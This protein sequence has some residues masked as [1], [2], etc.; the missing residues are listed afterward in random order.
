M[1]TG[2]FQ[3]APEVRGDEDTSPGT[4]PT[5]ALCAARS[6]VDAALVRSGVQQVT[7]VAKYTRVRFGDAAVETAKVWITF[8]DGRIGQGEGHSREDAIVAA[9][10]HVGVS[11]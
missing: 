1:E 11:L 4:T 3:V 10:E 9:L 5:C 6:S 8:A 7:L 2:R